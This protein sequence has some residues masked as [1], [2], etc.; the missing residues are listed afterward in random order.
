MLN[1]EDELIHE[2]CGTPMY[3]APEIILNSKK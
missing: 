1:S 2:Q 3:M